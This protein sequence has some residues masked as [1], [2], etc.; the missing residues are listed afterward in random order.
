M[1]FNPEL[2]WNCFNANLIPY[3]LRKGSRLRTPPAKPVNYGK[4]NS[5][6]FRGTLLRMIFL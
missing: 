2:I 3:S 6:M 5:H 1:H 4:K